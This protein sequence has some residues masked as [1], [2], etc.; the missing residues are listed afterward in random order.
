MKLVNNI[1]IKL[2]TMNRLHIWIYLFILM[3][4]ALAMIYFYQPTCDAGDFYVHYNRLQ[5]LMDAIRDGKYPIY[6][7]YRMMSGYGYFLK[8]FY[9]DIILV[10]FALIGNYTNILTALNAMY[11]IS[12][13]LCG[14]FTY[15]ATKRIFKNAFTAS[16]AGL[17]FAFAAYRI[18]DFYVR[19]A[20]AEALSFTFIP[21]IFWGLYEIINGDYRKWYI[22]A[23]GFTL[24]IFSHLLASVLALLMIIIFLLIYNKSFRNEPKRIRYLLIAGLITFLLT[25]CY[26]WPM[27]E[28]M[29]SNTFYYTSKPLFG[30]ISYSAI[31]P[32]DVI[33]GMINGVSTIN[34]RFLPTIGGLII[35]PLFCRF[36][37]FET[38]KLTHAAD[39]ISIIGLVLLVAC[40]TLFP[41]N[42]FPFT[43]FNF[44]QFT[45]RLLE[46]SSLFLSISGA[47]YLTIALRTN[48][49]RL[50]TMIILL[51]IFIP[52]FIHGSI[53][54]R[55]MACNNKTP[56]LSYSYEYNG[57]IGAEYLP[58]KIPSVD[59]INKR[60]KDSIRTEQN[61]LIC[62][63]KKDEG[64]ITFEAETSGP[65]KVEL[66]LIYY[67]GYRARSD[68]KHIDIHESDNGLVEILVNGSGKVEVWY[69]GT[70]IQRIS[71]Y[72]S[73]ISIFMLIIYIFTINY[74]RQKESQ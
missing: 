22:I 24:T 47:Y 13:I 27:I 64:N 57:F 54:Y 50:M 46:F 14:L 39:I 66:P 3:F 72:V 56:E 21:I 73:L 11:L 63:F 40:T 34:T 41:W 12:T 30:S 16:I 8:A 20:I 9:C 69:E 71:W 68:N 42:I 25:S 58:A 33:L 32:H 49:R 15:I 36:F 52:I 61:T 67:K 65:D 29:L 2:P 60:G 53:A 6:M 31:K 44:I 4:L 19:G 51:V 45:W 10:P 62:Y 59:F 43:L 17:L 18:F 5:I 70:T 28:Q 7:D 55:I 74:R 38:T 37:I 23:I 48:M 1:I 35:F 26:I